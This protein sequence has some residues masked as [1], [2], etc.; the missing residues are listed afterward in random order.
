[1]DGTKSATARGHGLY[2]QRF[3]RLF[4]DKKNPPATCCCSSA[5]CEKIG[6]SHEGMF[7]IPKDEAECRQFL[8]KLGLDA[9]S[10]NRI[11]QKPRGIFVAP[12][13]FHP[14]HREMDEVT[15]RLKIKQLPEYKDD[16]GK[17]TSYAPPNYNVQEFI[18]FE[19]QSVYARGGY[20]IT[21]P[22]GSPTLLAYRTSRGHRKPSPLPTRRQEPQAISQ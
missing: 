8:T 19:I 6:Y 21:P 18:D 20:D 5:L 3:M 11:L 12:W 22:P 9:Q 7:S 14:R 17:V 16:E 4:G 1:M 13:H 15:G 10:R 2:G